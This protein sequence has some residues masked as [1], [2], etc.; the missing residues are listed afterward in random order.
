MGAYFTDTSIEPGKLDFACMGQLVGTVLPSNYCLV[1]T[2]AKSKPARRRI[3]SPAQ[4]YQL[5]NAL[6]KG[7]EIESRRYS[8]QLRLRVQDR[9]D[10]G[11]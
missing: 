6:S 11:N 2:R 1:R 9:N 8:A 10:K 5:L 3:A 7:I 4:G